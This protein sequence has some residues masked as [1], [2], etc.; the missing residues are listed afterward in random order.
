MKLSAKK[1]TAR[2]AACALLAVLN[3]CYSRREAEELLS[4]AAAPDRE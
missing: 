1:F 2:L 4:D 3:G